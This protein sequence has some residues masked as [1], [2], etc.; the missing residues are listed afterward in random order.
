MSTDPTGAESK[1]K[2]IQ[3]LNLE[4]SIKDWCKKYKN[5]KLYCRIFD[6]WGRD[7]CLY[8]KHRK[9]LDIPDMLNNWEKENR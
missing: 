7:L 9:L 2:P 5:G 3:H 6:N 1:F 8:C 4:L